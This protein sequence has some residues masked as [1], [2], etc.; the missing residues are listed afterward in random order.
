MSPEA[1]ATVDSDALLVNV[2]LNA[3]PDQPPFEPGEKLL[4][5]KTVELAPFNKNP[6]ENFV[7]IGLAVEDD[8][9]PGY[10]FE[11]VIPPASH[12]SEAGQRFCKEKF[13]DWM[14]CLGVEKTEAG[15]QVKDAIGNSFYAMCGIKDDEYG[16]RPVVTK[17]LKPV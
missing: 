6:K 12:M 7:K 16:K 3:I 5:L 4:T 17:L 1:K 10:I 15:Y 11:N 14:T 13:L 9:Y 2:D 8:P